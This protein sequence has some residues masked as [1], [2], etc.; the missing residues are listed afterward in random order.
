M[1]EITLTVDRDEDSGWFVA[2]WDAPRGKGG[3]TT[4]GRD[5]REL[6]DNIKEAVRC[7]FGKR[8]CV[9]HFSCPN[10]SRRL[11]SRPL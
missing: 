3:I 5:L 10:R 4:Q 8:N 2:S 1:K 7:H 9:G 6:Q 11:A